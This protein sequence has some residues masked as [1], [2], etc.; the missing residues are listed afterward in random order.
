MFT[1]IQ[2]Y[3]ILL[4]MCMTHSLEGAAA[5]FDG[6]NDGDLQDEGEIQALIESREARDIVDLAEV[7]TLEAAVDFAGSVDLSDGMNS[8]EQKTIQYLATKIQRLKGEPVSD[9]S[10]DG[11]IGRGSRTDI[12]N[13]SGINIGSNADVNQGV[14]EALISNAGDLVIAKRA[15]FALQ[16][17]EAQA[18][19]ERAATERAENLQVVAAFDPEADN[20]DEDIK[21][22]QRALI[23]LGHTLRGS[24]NGVD[25]DFGGSTRRA[26]EASLPEAR[27]AELVSAEDHLDTVN[28]SLQAARDVL[29]ASYDEIP[30]TIEEEIEEL[31]ASIESVDARI[32][33]LMRE[34]D[35]LDVMP[36]GRA[37]E[38][39]QA[40]IT[41]VI[42]QLLEMKGRLERSLELAQ[43]HGVSQRNQLEGDVRVDEMR[44]EIA[45]WRVEELRQD[46]AIAPDVYSRLEIEGDVTAEAV[47]EA[48]KNDPEGRQLLCQLQADMRLLT[49]QDGNALY[50]GPIDGHRGVDY[51]FGSGTARA[52]TAAL[53]MHGSL[54]G[55]RRAARLAEVRAEA[56]RN[57]G[58]GRTNAGLDLVAQELRRNE[59]GSLDAGSYEPGALE[60]FLAENRVTADMPDELRTQPDMSEADR[61]ELLQRQRAWVIEQAIAMGDRE[62]ASGT[63]LTFIDGLA[64]HGN[65]RL[66]DVMPE[67]RSNFETRSGREALATAMLNGIELSSEDFE[68]TSPV[69]EIGDRLINKEL[70]DSAYIATGSDVTTDI[71]GSR[72]RGTM[73]VPIWNPDGS[74]N[75]KFAEL[76]FENA[77]YINGAIV[78]TMQNGCEGNL[79]IIPVQRDKYT[80]P[81]RRTTPGVPRTSTG[82]PPSVDLPDFPGIE[83]DCN[84][85]R[86]PGT[87]VM[88]YNGYEV[89]IAADRVFR[90][91]NGVVEQRFFGLNEW[92]GYRRMT[93]ENVRS[94]IGSIMREGTIN[95]LFF[96]LSN[97]WETVWPAENVC[98]DP[99]G[100]WT[101]TGGWDGVGSN[102]GIGG[103]NGNNGHGQSF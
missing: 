1:L 2:N 3:K 93:A 57:T 99:T 62:N 98:H 75:E 30:D 84:D 16:A 68:T 60:R 25:G 44:Q 37:R 66:A 40:E 8:I 41:E 74:L 87:H 76:D 94:N 32:A 31:E 61:A 33:E 103:P 42:N 4:G 22:L 55:I 45:E 95:F 36:D 53:E 46:L 78:M 90:V 65:D 58:E 92:I 80:P 52:V 26:Y 69:L 72:Q 50:T 101:G 97:L 82:L 86:V 85:E 70:L 43:E 6:N 10:I 5:R 81:V 13:A 51:G 88:S 17:A 11:Q 56:E 91:K 18:E 49:D 7:E 14:L 64:Q 59:D 9:G 28:A 39:M 71:D 35:A 23:A 89:Y 15:E 24:N 27:Q 19:A 63:R 20:S 79:V 38:T 47:K 34:R 83:V 77:T 48:L 67:L 73:E 54:L 102:P 100:G 96:R 21:A 29:S 12:Q